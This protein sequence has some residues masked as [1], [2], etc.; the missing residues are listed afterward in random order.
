[1]QATATSKQNYSEKLS[2]DTSSEIYQVAE[3]SSFPLSEQ[4]RNELEQRLQAHEK[5]PK[6]GKPW[7]EVLAQ[8]EAML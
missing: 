6:Q 2:Q 7:R 8:L 4:Q 3:P 1:M 5:N